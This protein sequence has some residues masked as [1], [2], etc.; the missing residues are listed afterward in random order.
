MQVVF[1]F[2]GTLADT[3]EQTIGLLREIHPEL[4]AEHVELYRVGGAKKALAS[5]KPSMF[6]VIRTVGLVQKGQYKIVA[7]ARPFGGIKDLINDLR[8]EG[9]KVGILSKN[10]AENINKWL[11]KWQIEVDF[12]ETASV[13]VSKEKILKKMK[14]DFY[15][16]DEV[17]DVEACKK[18]GVKIIAVSWGF[19][20]KQSLIDAGAD[21]VVERVEEILDIVRK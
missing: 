19:N 6:E 13:M 9:I 20:H 16:G 15:V 3:W 12:L 1:D 5:L 8:T 18:V 11:N 14:I 10:T 17:R 4:T 7:K 21:W 2:D